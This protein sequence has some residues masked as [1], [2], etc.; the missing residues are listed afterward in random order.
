MILDWI[1]LWKTWWISC[2][3]PE[4]GWSC[5]Y[6]EGL[7]G[8]YLGNGDGLL[9]HGFVNGHSVVFSHLSDKEKSLAVILQRGQRL[10]GGQKKERIPPYQTR[11][12]RPLRRRPAPWLRPPWWSRGCWGLAAP[13]PSDQLHCCPCQRCT[14]EDPP[15]RVNQTQTQ[16]GQVCRVKFRHAIMLPNPHPHVISLSSHFYEIIWKLSH[17]NVKIIALFHESFTLQR[18]RFHVISFKFHVFFYVIIFTWFRESFTL[19]RESFK[20]SC[21]HFQVILWNYHVISW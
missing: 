20:L 2:M 15:P 14:P 1:L 3:K 6:S 13:R 7:S 9:L 11:R 4:H 5:N 12:C 8:W 19:F 21:D 17:Y 10:D 18:D 16:P